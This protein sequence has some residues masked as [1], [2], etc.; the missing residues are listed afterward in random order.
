MTEYV[1][2]ESHDPIDGDG[3]GHSG[4]LPVGSV[5]LEPDEPPHDGSWARAPA[6]IM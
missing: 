6:Q 3:L 5:N 1:L 2:I 4:S